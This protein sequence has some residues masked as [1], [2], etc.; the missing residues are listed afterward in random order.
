MISSCAATDNL[1]APFIYSL[2]VASNF[3]GLST[4]N[5]GDV[6]FAHDCFL[7]N[8]LP[9]VGSLDSFLLD[10]L[11][12]IG[13]LAIPQV[14]GVL[15]VTVS[16]DVVGWFEGN[17]N[18]SVLICRASHRDI[19]GMSAHFFYLCRRNSIL[20]AFRLVFNL[21]LLLGGWRKFVWAIDA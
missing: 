4:S 13:V 20:G 9:S 11:L 21:M 8:F 5:V 6:H 17:R 2:R 16:F 19:G 14:S 1:S 12:V 15:A 18:M 7:C 3:L 10:G